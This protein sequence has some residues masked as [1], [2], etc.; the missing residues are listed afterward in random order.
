MRNLGPV[1][2]KMR[3][4]DIEK[5]AAELAGVSAA[6]LDDVLNGTDLDRVALSVAIQRKLDEAVTGIDLQESTMYFNLEE[7][8]TEH[9][10]K[11]QDTWDYKDSML[12]FG[13]LLGG[14]AGLGI[15]LYGLRGVLK[16]RA[17]VKANRRELMRA[18]AP[19]LDEF[20]LQLNTVGQQLAEVQGDRGRLVRGIESVVR[21]MQAVEAMIDG[22]LRELRS[23]IDAHDLDHKKLPDEEIRS[24]REQLQIWE[25]VAGQI[26]S[27]LGR[28]VAA[29]RDHA[30]GGGA[31]GPD[32][33]TA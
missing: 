31:P 3:N 12:Q 7:Y 14:L 30:E 1:R 24:L 20:R 33:P 25:E 4:E 32:A 19:I 6:S 9:T 26:Y 10:A 11:L 17:E 28:E 15:G 22:K 21:A 16:E 2:S 29:L 18:L 5:R 27:T 13:L 8:G 23:Q